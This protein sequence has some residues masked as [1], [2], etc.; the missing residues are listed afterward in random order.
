[1]RQLRYM[2]IGRQG[3]PLLHTFHIFS[4]SVRLVCFRPSVH[5]CTLLTCGGIM[6]MHNEAEY[7][8]L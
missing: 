1:M 2:S 7:A 8:A 6:R 3:N 5:P 4:T